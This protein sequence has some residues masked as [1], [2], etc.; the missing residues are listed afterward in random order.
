MLKLPA[1]CVERV[2]ET[3]T[4]AKIECFDYEPGDEEIVDELCV[5]CMGYGTADGGADADE[6]E[7]NPTLMLSDCPACEGTGKTGQKIAVVDV[8]RRHYED[9]VFD[10]DARRAELMSRDCCPDCGVGGGHDLPWECSRYDGPTPKGY[11]EL[12]AFYGDDD[13][14]IYPP[15]TEEDVTIWSEKMQT[16]LNAMSFLQGEPR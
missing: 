12:Q 13:P 7:A 5:W 4:G 14:T 10:I 11:R 1:T 6:V 2:T 8:R 3:A 15:L 16:A 9:E